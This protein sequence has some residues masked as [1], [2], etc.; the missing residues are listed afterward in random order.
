MQD[1]PRSSR[2]AAVD[3]NGG[4]Y[5]TRRG[6]PSLGARKP[7][8]VAPV[9]NQVITIS[10][11]GRYS[12]TYPETD[13][14]LTCSNATP[15]DVIGRNGMHEAMSGHRYLVADGP[16]A[17]WNAPMPAR[18]VYDVAY[19]ELCDMDRELRSAWRPKSPPHAPRANC[20]AERWV[21]TVRGRVHGP[22]ADLWREPSPSRAASI[23]RAL[24]RSSAALVAERA[25]TRPG[26]A[27]RGA[28]RRAGTAP[29]GARRRDQR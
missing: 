23:R 28:A 25:A 16:L 17:R 3:Q 19:C 2:A 12:A 5:G 14:R 7:E 9:T 10:G 18:I 11:N 26:R 1:G 8:C 20:Y 13:I 24:Q 27:S 22:N 6:S 29:Q 21:R 15:P 4:S